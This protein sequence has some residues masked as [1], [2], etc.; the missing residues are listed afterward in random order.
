MINLL[1]PDYRLH[2]HFSRINTKLR[3]WLII[4]VVLIVVLILILA[5]GWLYMNEQIEELNKSIAT[6]QSELQSKNLRD[7]QKQAD[8]ISQNVRII[9]QVL[10]REIRFSDL[11]QAVGKVMPPGT[12]LGSLTLGK[13]NGAL[14][15]TANT[16]DY[17]SAAQIAVN[18]SDPKN[19]L[20]QKVDII[21]VVCSGGA[22]T[23]PC[24][25]N[26]K[27]LFSKDTQLKFLNIASGGSQ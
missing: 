27:T 21:N 14:D 2:M 13:V 10:G 7:V 11:I 23:Y 18:L 5:G 15:I 22:K 8:E 16:K 1:P 12:V 19:Q 17:P 24:T 9:S 26:F 6:T 20:F 4:G 3:Q 25:A